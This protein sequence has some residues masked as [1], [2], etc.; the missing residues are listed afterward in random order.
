MPVD[1]DSLVVGQEYERPFLAD[2]WGYKGFQAISRGVVTPADT[3]FIILFVT[4]EKQE[5]LTQYNDYISNEVLFW[6]GEDKHGSDGRVV[7]A[8]KRGDEIHLFYR[9]IHHFPFRYYGHV[10]L[11]KHLLHSRK[12]SSFEFNLDISFDLEADTSDRKAMD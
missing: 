3:N 11:R 4:K 8:G 12:P 7:N 10:Y 1:F 6:E 5:S 2:L 9:K